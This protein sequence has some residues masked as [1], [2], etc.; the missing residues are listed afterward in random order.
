MRRCLPRSPGTPSMQPGVP[1]RGREA[2]K[3]QLDRSRPLRALEQ[4]AWGAWR[5]T[6]PGLRRRTEV[7]HLGR[8]A[9]GS[10]PQ[11]ASQKAPTRGPPWVEGACA[12]LGLPCLSPQER[13]TPRAQL[14]PLPSGELGQLGLP[15][16]ARPA[17]PCAC[18]RPSGIGPAAEARAGRRGGE[19]R[20]PPHR[21]GAP[22]PVH[23]TSHLWKSFRPPRQVIQGPVGAPNQPWGA[24]VPGV[25]QVTGLCQGKAAEGTWL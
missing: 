8:G 19:Q 11:P 18:S 1:Q 15:V 2:Q 20:P 24:F 17:G 6:S 14:H 23:L 21:E 5:G 13:P 16:G 25:G 7:Q 10:L 22:F 4:Q 9:P 3:R 12:W